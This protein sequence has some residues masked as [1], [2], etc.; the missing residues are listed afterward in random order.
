MVVFRSLTPVSEALNMSNTEI[1]KAIEAETKDFAYYLSTEVK[2]L[3]G[4]QYVTN[5][6]WK[7]EAYRL[8]QENSLSM[9]DRI[10]KAVDNKKVDQI[11]ELLEESGLS[12]HDIAE[13][14]YKNPKTTGYKM[15]LLNSRPDSADVKGALDSEMFNI[16]LLRKKLQLVSHLSYNLVEYVTGTSTRTGS[17]KTEWDIPVADMPS[18]IIKLVDGVEAIAGEDVDLS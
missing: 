12:T 6:S 4:D 2:P 3:Q 18:N 1:Q 10:I 17:K 15:R 9:E 11:L 8:F 16:K 14:F 13:S 7:D 5:E